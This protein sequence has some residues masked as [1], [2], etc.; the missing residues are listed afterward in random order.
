MNAMAASR[1]Q[2]LERDTSTPSRWRWHSAMFSWVV[3]KNYAKNDCEYS[4]RR[5]ALHR[6]CARGLI[7]SVLRHL[8]MIAIL[9]TADVVGTQTP[10]L[11]PYNV[12]IGLAISC[13]DQLFPFAQTSRRKKGLT[14]RALAPTETVL[15][16]VGFM[17]SKSGPTES[18][19]TSLRPI[20]DR[21]A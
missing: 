17:E 5:A 11:G 16:E 15:V 12:R 21:V 20:Q 2:L 4:L 6:S 7:A 18:Q 3:A 10:G 14:V 9:A 1:S 19:P 8:P 13:S